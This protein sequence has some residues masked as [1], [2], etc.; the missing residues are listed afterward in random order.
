MNES[1]KIEAI[2]Q[3]LDSGSI[4]IFGRPFAGKDSQCY[5][6]AEILGGKVISGGEILRSSDKVSSLLKR[7][8]DSG[9]MAPS[10]EYLNIIGNYLGK[11]EL[12]GH[13]LILS[14]VGR[15]HGEEYSVMQAL[16]KSS[17]PL[18][19]A[20]YLNITEEES[21]RRWQ[22]LQENNDRQNRADDC[23]E[24]LKTRNQEFIKNTLPV[25]Q[26]YRQ[27]NLLIEIDGKQSRKDVT[28]DIIDYIY[29]KII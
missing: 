7:D 19:I 15:L 5:K 13:P 9:K 26:Y 23:E 6:I 16:T 10:Q 22:M 24:I 4:N 2:K 17:H 11:K 18:K 21:F 8:I 25:L 29:Q 12:S 3:W 28:Q 20:V 27:L 14:S 1:K